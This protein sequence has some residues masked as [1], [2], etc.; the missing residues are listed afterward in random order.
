ML[1][2]AP[3]FE[4]SH[5]HCVAICSFLVPANLLATLQTLIFVALHRSQV[6]VRGSVLLAT[7]FALVLSLH[8]GT[9]FMI[10]VVRNVTFIL[11]I[12]ATTC[13]MINIFAVIYAKNLQYLVAKLG[14]PA[15]LS[16]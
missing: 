14:F 3:V 6:Q 11:L 1:D 10:G 7:F 15:R 9:W 13:L 5:H 2:L 12:L 16:V 4:F 8:V